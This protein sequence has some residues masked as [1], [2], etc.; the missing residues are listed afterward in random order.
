MTQYF[1]PIETTSPPEDKTV[2]FTN[3]KYIALGHFDGEDFWIHNTGNSYNSGDF[4]TYTPDGDD[5]DAV[6]GYFGAYQTPT[7]WAPLPQMPKEQQP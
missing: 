1:Q 5:D 3:G 2:I 4:I 6:S 7:H